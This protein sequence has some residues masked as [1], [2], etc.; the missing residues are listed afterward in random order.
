MSRRTGG[1]QVPSS[2]ESPGGRRARPRAVAERSGHGSGLPGRIQAPRSPRTGSDASIFIPDR[3]LPDAPRGQGLAPSA[4]APHAVHRQTR[5]AWPARSASARVPPR[6][7]GCSARTSRVVHVQP[8]GAGRGVD[9]SRQT[10]APQVACQRDGVHQSTP[11][12]PSAPRTWR[13]CV[14]QRRDHLIRAPVAGCMSPSRAAWRKKR[15]RPGIGA[16]S[17]E[18][19]A[20][21]RRADGREVRADLVQHAGEDAHL[22]ERRVPGARQHPEVGERLAGPSAP[23]LAPRG[24]VARVVAQRQVDLP[25]VGER[26]RSPAPR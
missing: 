17:V 7:G 2:R 15:A 23:A 9:L 10:G 25:L 24:R 8:P 16:S 22:H 21:E 19:V 11:S 6:A 12:S 26:A 13:S 14:R 3:E 1:R 18:R 4:R 5:T 20:H